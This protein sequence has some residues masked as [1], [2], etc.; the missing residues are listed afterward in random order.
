[1]GENRLLH[2][3]E[4]VIIAAIGPITAASCR[5]LGLEVHIQPEQYT[6]EKMTEALVHHFSG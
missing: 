2:L 1:M 3:L 4:G 6:L 5:D